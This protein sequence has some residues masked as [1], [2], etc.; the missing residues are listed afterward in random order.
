[1]I[2][3][4]NDTMILNNNIYTLNGYRFNINKL[5]SIINQIIV[6]FKV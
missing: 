6:P 4:F 3:L 1:M 5:L 2:Q